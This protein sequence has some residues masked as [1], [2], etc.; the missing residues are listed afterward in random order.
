[1][2]RIFAAACLVACSVALPTL[3]YDLDHKKDM[4]GMKVTADATG[5]PNPKVVIANGDKAIA[6]CRVEFVFDQRGAVPR[7]ASVRPGKRV[8]LTAPAPE[9]TD[10]L[11]VTTACKPPKGK[12]E[13][14]E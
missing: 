7:A 11:R 4:N 10:K 9:G 6:H 2:K 14:A 8:I 1:M 12:G 13:K 5:G 3:A